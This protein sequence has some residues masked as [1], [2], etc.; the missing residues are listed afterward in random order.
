MLMLQGGVKAFV[1]LLSQVLHKD[2]NLQHGMPANYGADNATRCVSCHYPSVLL[3][4]MIS[5]TMHGVSCCMLGFSKFLSASRR[6]AELES[7]KDDLEAQ[8]HLLTGQIA[9]RDE[10]LAKLRQGLGQANRA[11]HAKQR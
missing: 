7:A 1:T 6:V 4:R 9:L 10:R 2:I 8:L 5:S 11:L 3:F